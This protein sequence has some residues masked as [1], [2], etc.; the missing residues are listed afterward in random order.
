ME[1]IMQRTEGVD[2]GRIN[3]DDAR[4]GENWV[5]Q[6]RFR[7]DLIGFGKEV[8]RDLDADPIA[9]CE[10][11]APINEGPE[12]RKIVMSGDGIGKTN[13][14]SSLSNSSGFGIGE[15]GAMSEYFIS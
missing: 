1:W 3:M 15:S 11:H 12:K 10:L 5:W 4:S 8:R 6:D 2:G 14:V 7:K 13:V 9:A